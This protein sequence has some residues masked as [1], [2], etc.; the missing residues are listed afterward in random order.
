MSAPWGGKLG[1]T[2]RKTQLW[3]INLYLDLNSRR[4]YGRGQEIEGE[5]SK[6]R[7]LGKN[8]DSTFISFVV[9]GK[10]FIHSD[11]QSL[12]LKMSVIAPPYSYV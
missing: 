7:G 12:P 8:L 10:S 1:P 9:L 11:P 3:G 4:E 2:T 5:A 6:S